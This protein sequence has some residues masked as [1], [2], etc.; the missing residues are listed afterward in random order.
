MKSKYKISYYLR[1]VISIAIYIIFFGYII[2]SM[3]N[4]KNT[5]SFYFNLLVGI[6]I[7]GIGL[8]YEYL[9]IC[10]DAATK[11]LVIDCKPQECLKFLN[12]VE[13]VDFF[14][15]YRTSINMMKMLAMMDLRKFDQ[16][17]QFIKK[18]DEE[19]NY[20]YDSELIARYALM[21]AYGEDGAKGKSNEAF[22]QLI[23]LRDK[24]DYKGRRRAG[25]FYLNWEVVNG[26]HKN[27][28][29]DYDAGLRYLSDV[30][31]ANLN[32]REVMHYLLAKLISAKESNQNKV[33]EETKNRLLKVAENNKVMIDYINT[34]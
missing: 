2:Y 16:L 1:I 3:I 30:N 32:R 8:L 28:D 19:D 14:K 10:Y 15:T 5:S 20:D 18:L 25:A 17:K 22:K 7:G 12:R 33:F 34:I 13:K 9:R 6:I 24:K 29:G 23:N 4:A 27:Y 26:Q 11:R 31:E 21:V